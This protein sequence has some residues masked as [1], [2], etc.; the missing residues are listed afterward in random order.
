MVVAA[1]V[2]V[3][4]LVFEGIVIVHL[5]AIVSIVSSWRILYMVEIQRHGTLRFA[6]SIKE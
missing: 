3:L 1:V 6:S 5:M 4:L 2:S